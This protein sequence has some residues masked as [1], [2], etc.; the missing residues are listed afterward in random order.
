MVARVCF[1]LLILLELRLP[2]CLEQPVGSLLEKH[3]MFAYLVRKYDVYKEV[4]LQTILP[5][6]ITG[7]SFSRGRSEVHVW[8]GAYGAE[9]CWS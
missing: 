7:F 8:L 9:S 4:R 3:P 6:R 5:L 1:Y 2:W